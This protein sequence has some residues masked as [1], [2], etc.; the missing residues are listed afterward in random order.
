MSQGAEGPSPPPSPLDLAFPGAEILSSEPL[1]GGR[2]NV[3]Y[4]VSVAGRP[5]PFVV[6]VHAGLT[7][8]VAL[9]TSGVPVLSAAVATTYQMLTALGLE[10]NVPDAGHLLSGAFPMVAV[11]NPVSGTV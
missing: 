5:H 6:R 11:N 8:Y 9:G 2:M 3:N 10:P 1:T 7:P 4:K